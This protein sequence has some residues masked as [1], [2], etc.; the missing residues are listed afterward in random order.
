MTRNN[1]N[2]HNWKA[3]FRF[4]EE[5]RDKDILKLKL[6]EKSFPDDFDF[7]FALTQI[8]CR[9]KCKDKLKNFINNPNF[10]FPDKISSE[11]ASH[12][13]VGRFHAGLTG[14]GK[15]L[16]DMTA[17]LGI[18][19]LSMALNDNKVLA[20]EKDSEKAKALIHNSRLFDLYDFKVLNCDSCEFIK[21]TEQKFDFIFIDPARRDSA[22]KR[23]YNLR[24]CSPDVL[25]M[26]PILS[27]KAKHILIKASPMLDI[28]QTVKD[29]S[30]ISAIKVVGVKG[31]CKEVLII[32]DNNADNH[33]SNKG[34]RDINIEA[35]DM[36]N[37]GNIINSLSTKLNKVSSDLQKESSNPS[38]FLTENDII[39]GKFL[40]EPSA[41]IMKIA[42]WKEIMEKYDAIK[43]GHSSHLFIS[44]KLP[45]D[46]P[47]RVTEIVGIIK[48]TDRRNLKG[49]EATVVSKNHPLSSAELRKSLQIK[50]GDKNF[51]YATKTGQKPV[52]ILTKSLKA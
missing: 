1:N 41:M 50:E 35:L 11:Q 43:F 14:T 42:P 10:L 44:E 2:Q 39:P 7:D 40:L 47:G 51:I 9:K 4:I 19:A 18:D 3:F 25:D 21:D 29:F 45:E 49:M 52:L 32:I 13:A 15:S 8:E 6:N 34:H 22:N 37:E 31:E 26:M 46:F 17:G 38:S 20:V 48:K 23:V 5:N 12:Q 33:N 16:I 27:E 28:S 36:D 24:D 30:N